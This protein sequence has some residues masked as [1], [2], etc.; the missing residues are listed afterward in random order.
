M[1]TTNDLNLIIR[2][3]EIQMD[4]SPASIA[5]FAASYG[6]MK[7]AAENMEKDYFFSSPNFLEEEILTWAEMIYPEK[8][9]NGYR[10]VPVVVGGRL[11]PPHITIPRLM[12]E[13]CEAVC[14]DRI[15]DSTEVYRQFELIHP[16]VDGNGRTGMLLWMAHM[17]YKNGRVWP[18]TLP[19]NV[20][21]D[22][23]LEN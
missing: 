21:G 13:F 11:A 14:E 17:Y 23:R 16:F 2:E 9:K 4:T 6:A 8:N 20:F 1:I 7:Y 22:P 19:P 5:G 15:D 18:E 12:A 3:C 10:N